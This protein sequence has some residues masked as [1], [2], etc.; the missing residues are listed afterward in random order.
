MLSGFVI[1]APA[2]SDGMATAYL[3]PER[4]MCSHTPPPPPNQMVRLRLPD[5]WQPREI[6]EPARFSGRLEIAPSSRTVRVVDGM[7]S[8][9]TT[10]TMDVSRIETLASSQLDRASPTPLDGSP[11]ARLSATSNGRCLD[12]SDTERSR[13]RMNLCADE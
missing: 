12:D 7:V 10:F 13:G 9:R 8:M 5:D 3:V 4:G 1:P 11:A 2:V 6:Y